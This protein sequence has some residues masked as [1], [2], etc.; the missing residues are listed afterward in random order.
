LSHA[1]PRGASSGCLNLPVPLHV[2]AIREHA[3]DGSK[4]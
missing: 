2:M 3:V 4:E 1:L